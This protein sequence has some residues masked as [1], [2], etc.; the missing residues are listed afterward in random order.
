MNPKVDVYVVN[1]QYYLSIMY[2]H[3]CE[4]N[5]SYWRKTSQGVRK[6]LFINLDCTTEDFY[7]GEILKLILCISFI[8]QQTRRWECDVK[9]VS[10]VY[11]LLRNEEI[12]GT[13]NIGLVAPVSGHGGCFSINIP[14]YQYRYFFSHDWFIFVMGIA[15]WKTAFDL[16][17]CPGAT[18]VEVIMLVEIGVT[19][20]SA[21]SECENG[22]SGDW[23]I[24]TS[25]SDSEIPIVGKWVIGTSV[26]HSANFHSYVMRRFGPPFTI[27][28]FFPGLG[29][30]I[31]KIKQSVFILFGMVYICI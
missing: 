25:V 29:I 18:S 7:F 21:A 4:K 10:T 6:V 12:N 9:S 5:K 16:K 23:V 15:S 1:V 8:S 30:L 17:R 19:R 31:I 13:P 27:E 24:G 11:V 20:T 14:S 3:P 22:Y 28:T 26:S 2:T